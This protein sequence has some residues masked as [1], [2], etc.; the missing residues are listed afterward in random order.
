MT[1]VPLLTATALVLS[2]LPALAQTA[3]IDSSAL[4]D[5]AK[6]V[7][8]PIPATLTAIK[9]TDA[10]PEGTALTPEK[11]ALGKTLFFDPRMSRSGLISCQTCHNVGLGGVDGL[12]T[13]VGHGW[14]KGPRNA[15]TMLN[16]IF[17]AAQFW[18]GRAPD[19]A[20]QAKGPV[21]AS[22][23]MSNTPD[24]VVATLN[25]MPGY[26]EAFRSAFPGQN[27]PVSF[28][29]F[30][31][32]IEQ[33]EATLI[34]PDSAFDRFLAGDDAAM[35]ETQ[36]R[37]LQAFLGTGCTACHY[38]VNLGGQDYYPFGLVARPGAEV[39]PAGDTGRFEVTKTVDDEYVFRAA[40]LRNVAL[41]APYF[42]SGMVWDLHEA[43]QIMSSSQLGTEL[44][45]AQVGDI[46]AFLGS[47]TGE[48]PRI[49][50]PILPVRSD[51][52]PL[53]SPM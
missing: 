49:E 52:T 32:A 21:Q 39:L 22:V 9:Q 29:N 35:D 11:I 8:E 13:S 46:V 24:A 10:T 5:E 37:G 38:G 15:P 47:L 27:D 40:P 20:E 34:T 30:A 7:F 43:V 2:A 12:P 19:L 6:A 17:N 50:H 42:H 14:Q 53:P 28:D 1:S 26:V 23:E 4:R 41:T 33:F 16:A 3:A 25:S 36:K 44:T 18:D 31:A 48:Q 51:T 45:E